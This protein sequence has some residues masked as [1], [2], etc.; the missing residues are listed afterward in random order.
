MS[1][2]NN[3]WGK[4]KKAAN[5]QLVSFLSKKSVFGNKLRNDDYLNYFK[6]SDIGILSQL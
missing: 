6:N 1:S 5:P 2:I 3:L 4:D